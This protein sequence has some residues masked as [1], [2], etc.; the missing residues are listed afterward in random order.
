MVRFLEL[1][2]PISPFLPE[3]KKPERKVSFNKRLMWTLLAMVAYLIMAEVPL[4]GVD[5]TQSISQSYSVQQI[6]MASTDYT[7]LHLG[8][9][10]IVTAGLILQL[11]SGAL[12]EF[13]NRNPEDRALFQT[14]SK[15]FSI[16]MIL[17]QAVL[18]VNGGQFG[19]LD[20]GMKLIVLGQLLAAGIVIILLD[21]M[22]QKGWGI[23]SGI[24]LFIVA[25]ITKNLWW[26]SF[27]FITVGDGKAFGAIPAFIQTIMAGDNWVNWFYRPGGWPSMIG[28]FATIVVF[29]FVIYVE[30]MRVELPL[31][32]ASYRGFRS[33]MPIKLLYV[34]NIPV[35]LAFTAFQNVYLIGWW[36]WQSFNSLNANAILNAIAMYNTTDPQPMAPIGGLAYYVTSPGTFEGI[37]ADPFKAIIYLLIIVGTCVAFSLIW[38]EIGGIGPED[39]ADQLLGSGMQVPGFRRS[40]KPLVALLNRY[41]PTITIIGGLI[42][43]ILA[44]LSDYFGVF[45]SGMGA[46][47]CVSIMYQ[48]D[49]VMVQ[50]QVEDLY[51]FLRGAF[52]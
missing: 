9:G 13:D 52:S 33:K 24:S 8:I 46:L 27:S 37:T 6:I 10:P 20:F 1:F 18:M 29:A 51:P 7:L 26:Q 35:I 28:L 30:G 22:I 21:E 43:G 39:M 4:Y 12:I 45:G 3:V 23:G 42:I 5:K 11:L 17:L 15:L 34:S 48:Y 47:L 2:K 25:G 36:I 44:A 49:Q 16:L 38:L 32:H 31:S 41:I 50:E 19:N 14:V 40:K